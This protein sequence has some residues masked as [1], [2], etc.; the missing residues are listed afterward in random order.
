MSHEFSPSVRLSASGPPAS[1]ASRRLCFT[2]PI[3]GS[4]LSGNAA[5]SVLQTPP[6]TT[7]ALTGH[8]NRVAAS[9]VRHDGLKE[10][11]LVHSTLC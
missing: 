5:H 1:Y 11:R 9:E 2:M 8:L 7:E 3:L 10:G 6:V 4:W